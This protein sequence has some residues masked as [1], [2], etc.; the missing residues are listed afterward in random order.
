MPR[1]VFPDCCWWCPHPCGEILLTHASIGNPPTLAG[2]FD[3]VSCGSTAPFIWVLVH[4]RFCLFPSRLEFLFPPLLC[5]SYNQNLLAFK[6]RFPGDSQSL[7]W[8]PRLGSLTWV[9]EPSQQWGNFF[10]IIVLQFVSHPPGR[11]GIW[12]YHDCAPSTISLW[13]LLCLWTWG[14]FSGKFQ[15][16]NV[17]CCPTTLWFWCFHHRLWVHVLLLHHLKQEVMYVC[18]FKWIYIFFYSFHWHQ[19]YNTGI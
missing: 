1:G 4:E 17:N 2:S 14:I 3:P 8:I 9:S 10:G 19:W 15:H 11:H 5:K 18:V 6:V 16:P 13:L 12:F 7:C